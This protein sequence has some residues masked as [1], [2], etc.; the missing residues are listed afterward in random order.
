MAFFHN[1][2]GFSIK[3]TETVEDQLLR[4]REER[5][6]LL[7][8]GYWHVVMTKVSPEDYLEAQRQS[9][10]YQRKSFELYHYAHYNID[11]CQYIYCSSCNSS[12]QD[13]L[14]EMGH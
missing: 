12:C 3:E 9:N 14:C 6:T 8:F 11:R 4:E 2:F 10:F 1:D 13:E 7:A 5:I